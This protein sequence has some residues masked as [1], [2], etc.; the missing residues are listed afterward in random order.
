MSDNFIIPISYQGKEIEVP[1]VPIRT[2]Y[3]M[4]FHVSIAD[5]P[6]IIEFDEEK[7]YRVINPNPQSEIK[8]DTELIDKLIETLSYLRAK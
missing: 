1:A 4:Q 3:T 5:T 7:E 6:L 2:G 8:V